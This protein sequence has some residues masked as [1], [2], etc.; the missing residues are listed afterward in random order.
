MAKNGATGNNSNVTNGGLQEDKPKTKK[1]G[2][3]EP[4]EE[5]SFLD[6][7]YE[8][9]TDVIGGDN[10]NQY[11]C[12]TLPGTIVNPS[13][14]QYDVEGEK[15]AHVKANESKLVNKLFDA[16]FMTASDNGRQ[17]QNQYRTA[18]NMLSPK[19]NRDLFE[20]K[21]R[22]REVLMTPYQ[23]DFGNGVEDS[24]TLEQVF[25]RLYSDYV[26]A[27][28]EWNQ[29]QMDKKAELKRTIIDPNERRDAYLEWYGL[30]AETERVMLEEKLGKVLNVFSPGDM[31]IINGILNC[32]VGGEIENARSAMDMV[33]ELSPDGGYVYPV[34]L[35]PKNWFDL[36]DSSF[37]GVDLLE[38]PAA[39]SQRMKTLEMQRSNL[40]LNI[41]KLT[42]TIPDD[43]EVDALQ[44]AYQEAEDAF[45]TLVNECVN[46]NKNAT[47]DVVKGI[48][49]L[50]SKKSDGTLETPSNEETSRIVKSDE[51]DNEEQKNGKINNL[52]SVI[53]QNAT[54]CFDKQALAVEAAGKGTDAALR[55]CEAHNKQQLKGLLEPL[56]LQLESVNNEISELKDKIVLSKAVLNNP[57]DAA[58]DVMPNKE[59]EGFTQLLIQSKMSSV[60]HKS[61]KESEASNSSWGV[62][63][64]LGGYSCNKSHQKSV[65][66]SMDTSSDI[67]IQIGMNLAKVQIEREWFNP[68]VFLLTENM[69]NFSSSKIAADNN[70]SFTSDNQEEVQ[71]RFDEM[72]ECIFPVYPV[73]FVIAKDVSIRFMSKSS[74]STSFAESIEDHASQGGGFLIFSGNS[75]SSS[76]SGQ[77]AA[78]A[79]SN[80]NCVTVRFT[81]P[82]ILGYYMQATPADKSAYINSTTDTD[83]SVIGFVSKFKEM[84]DD[85]NKTLRE[86]R[87]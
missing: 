82:Q 50:C 8:N 85:Y 31:N 17:L 9:I 36:L 44:K 25:Y 42:S 49:S 76:S 39:L 10:P 28:A 78:T 62:S 60:S 53:S 46:A 2:E 74:M 69:Y 18:L 41:S 84:I 19:L 37:T 26:A 1:N 70:T 7:L 63:F 61:S 59:A 77:S 57:G 80:A 43:S 67:E 12:M 22:L 55:W 34:N 27:K 73:S 79:N 6:T 52:I 32:G 15:P 13:D 33:E 68:G 75:S 72:N 45:H 35:Y 71:K 24:M 21:V 51:T 48:V 29:K 23:Y 5:R 16:C 4:K 20:M 87:Q 47:A 11:F 81:A 58:A 56:K 65:E 30:V 38:S 83:M 86:S 64:L 14:Y 40:M 66:N 3:G 54:E